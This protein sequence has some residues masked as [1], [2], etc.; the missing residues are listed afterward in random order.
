MSLI[1]LVIPVY[2]SQKYLE[3]C[4]NSVIAQT[5]SN[6]E[7]ILVNDGSKDNSIEICREYQ[8]K[9]NR[10]RVID[11]V[12]E[13]VSVARNTGI[14]AARGAFIGFIDADD[15]IEPQM[16]E[17][18]YKVIEETDS[19]I[20]F[21]N[22]SKDT[23]LKSYVKLL[24]IE[25]HVLGK[26][27]IINELISNI[28]GI[29]DILP[30]YYNIMGCVWRCL[31]KKELIQDF[32]L[33]FNPNIKIMEDLIF[34][35][36]ALIHSQRVCIDHGVWYHYMQNKTS[37]LHTYIENMW[38]SQIAVHEI[39]EKLLTEANLDEY[40]RPRL[41]SRYIAMAACSLGNE[42][43]R[44][45]APVKDKMEIAKIIINDEKLKIALERAK[46]YNIENIKSLKG[47]SR[48]DVHKENRL[49]RHLQNF[50]FPE[51]SLNKK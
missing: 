39:L 36:E 34:N 26:T 27:D 51:D 2:N 11:K 19:D 9:D 43:Y 28:V 37:S 10:I 22:Y 16:Y 24:K 50:I 41:D 20:A 14:E 23:K 29:D 46:K 42:L 47:K 35:I 4:L 38:N 31:Y 17:S 33:R 1:S 3:R 44:S 12:N 8:K 6:I 48:D 40:M 45:N 5:H 32:N 21:C 49:I 30:K 18:M 13:G 15:W 7:I 25:K